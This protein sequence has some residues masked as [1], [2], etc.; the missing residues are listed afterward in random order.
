MVDAVH[1]LRFGDHAALFYADREEQLACV[2]PFI[3]EGLRN[4]EK[5]LYVANDNGVETILMRLAEAGID[6]E[7]ALASGA[8]AVVTKEDS[9]LRHG[10]FEPSQMTAELVD[11]T[12]TATGEG[13]RGFRITGETTWALDLPSALTRLI[14]YEERI[15]DQPMGRFIGLCQYDETR[16]S[17]QIIDEMVRLH[18]VVIRRGKLRRRKDGNRKGAGAHSVRQQFSSGDMPGANYQ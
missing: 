13:F 15:H 1:Q 18:P 9:Y 4:H 2:I 7:S 16:F 5:C 17:K 6:V 14:E 11:K 12:E 8:L 10:T 3:A